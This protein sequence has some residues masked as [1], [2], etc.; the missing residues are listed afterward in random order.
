MTRLHP[1]TGLA[2]ATSAAL[3]CL[4]ADRW[5]LSLAII[6]ACLALAARRRVGGRLAVAGGAVLAPLWLSQLLV[7]AAF[8]RTG[9]QV[10]LAGGP[11]RLTVE[12][13]TTA[14]GLGL[15]AGAFAAVFLL[16]SL[17]LDRHA[18]IRALDQA[19]LPAQLGYIIAAVLA[20]V[21]AT[22]ER[23][24]SIAQ[25]QAVRGA[26]GR[27]LANRLSSAR[28][29][30]VPLV[31]ASLQDATERSSALQLRGFPAGRERT[32]LRTVTARRWELPAGAA[33]LCLAA[34]LVVLLTLGVIR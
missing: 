22:M 34:L 23:A 10:L 6:L 21:P 28:L 32:Q 4:A 33:A 1:F 25:A 2:F 12:G 11:V 17:T 31:L 27:G 13:L 26:G 9:S 18:L 5:W 16:F 30:A 15:R 24:R 14:G 8:D 19:G 3:V 20:L 7:H 29:L